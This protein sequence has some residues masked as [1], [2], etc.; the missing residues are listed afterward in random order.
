MMLMRVWLLGFLGWAVVGSA[1]GQPTSPGQWVVSGQDA[2]MVLPPKPI[3]TGMPS[4]LKWSSTGKYLLSVRMEVNIDPAALSKVVRAPNNS[5]VRPQSVGSASLVISVW[6]SANQKSADLYK[7]DSGRA[8]RAQGEWLPTTDTAV[9]LITERS[10]DP[11]APEIVK[12]LR[13][14]NGSA[15][16]STIPLPG[17]DIVDTQLLVSDRYPVGAIVDARATINP[18]GGIQRGTQAVW[19]I[20]AQGRITGPFQLPDGFEATGPVFGETP[21]MASFGRVDRT[22]GKPTVVWVDFNLTTG[23]V[24]P[25]SEP[26]MTERATPVLPM[27]LDPDPESKEFYGFGAMSLYPG[28]ALGAKHGA[29][30][31]LLVSTTEKEGPR[32]LVAFDAPIAS[33][34]PGLNA[35]AYV[36]DD[37]LLVRTIVKVPK[38]IYVE[39]LAAAKRAEALSKVKQVGTALMIYASD[40]DDNLPTDRDLNGILDPYLKNSDLLA[41]FNYTFKGGN[42]QKVDKPAETELGYV[43]GP[44]GRAVVYADGHA[45]WV[46]D[47]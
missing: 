5:V 14:E 11:E 37:V 18:D 2:Y 24:R 25:G 12:L 40:Y 22:Q 6:N 4:L 19:G 31:R 7:V 21:A 35:V 39:A 46:P 43:I 38:S 17:P 15:S 10:D 13:F 33:L 44:G 20:N 29:S 34:S 28:A 27:R 23:E 26:K 42:L 3:G 30:P 32:A 9:V 36:T 41:G 45:R 16:I 47:K 1:W 8:G